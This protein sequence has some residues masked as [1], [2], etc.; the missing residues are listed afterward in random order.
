MALAA[1]LNEELT[2]EPFAGLVIVRSFVAVEGCEL[3]EPDEELPGSVAVLPELLEAL[4]DPDEELPGSVV[5]LPELLEA[6][7]DPVDVLPVPL[8]ESPEEFPGAVGEL[9]G[10]VVALMGSVAEPPH[11]AV[12]AV[13]SKRTEKGSERY[14]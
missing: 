5:V 7:P 8:P 9:P 3:P 1:T 11:P 14:I 12:I 4:P 13:A 6:L 2:L 10:E